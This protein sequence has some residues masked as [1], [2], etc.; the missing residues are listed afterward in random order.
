MKHNKTSL[1]T[2]L[3]G[4][5]AKAPHLVRGNAAED[6]ARQFLLDKGLTPVGRNFRCKHGEL[7]LIMKDG[8]T[9]VIV[10][11]RFRQSSQ[12]G[13]ALESITRNKQSRII[14]AT[15]VYLSKQKLDCPLRFDVVAISGDGGIEWIP[16]AF[17]S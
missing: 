11:V 10:E 12:Y 15:Q 8:R 1:L 6:K 4:I 13:S 3:A 2:L 17:S 14:A 9:L 7:D 16:N 5:P